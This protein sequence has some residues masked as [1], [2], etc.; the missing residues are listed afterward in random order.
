[1]LLTPIATEGRRRG[2]PRLP[3]VTSGSSC[4]ETGW[5]DPGAKSSFSLM[6]LFSWGRGDPNPK[7]RRRS[8]SYLERTRRFRTHSLLAPELQGIIRVTIKVNIP[9]N[10]IVYFGATYSNIRLRKVFFIYLVNNVN[11]DKVDLLWKMM[12][13]R[14]FYD[15]VNGGL[16]FPFLGAAFSLWPR[17]LHLQAL[18]V[19]AR[20]LNVLL[21]ESGAGGLGVGQVS[22]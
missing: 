7:A 18:R 4:Q 22:A 10:F 8:G 9:T 20:L 5:A 3:C 15:L 17:L 6:P 13:S 14:T 16:R 21:L 1:M 2:F 12:Y 19:L 11:V